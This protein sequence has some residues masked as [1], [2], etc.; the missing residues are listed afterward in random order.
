MISI[1]I[2]TFK[3]PYLLKTLLEKIYSESFKH[4]PHKLEIIIADNDPFHSAKKISEIFI[5]HSTIPLRIIHIPMPNIAA[6][7]NAA[8]G[9]SRGELLAFI[10]DDEIPCNEWLTQMHDAML[11][12][13]ADVIFGPV[14][15]YFHPETPQWIFSGKYFERQRYLTGTSINIS[16][17]RTGNV[18]I[19]R[20]S[21]A[22]IEGPFDLNFGRS[23]GEDT[24]FFKKLQH[25]GCKF[26][27]CDEA[28]V[29]EEVPLERASARWLLKRSYRIGQTWVRTE[30]YPCHGIQ[31]ASYW[32]FLFF[33]SIIQ[34]F[35][36][37]L[38]VIISFCFS[39]KKS[40]QWIRIFVAQIGKLTS[41]AGHQFR[42]YGH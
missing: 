41:L 25:A 21:F 6:A 20:K 30:L 5:N 11:L 14:I 7:R 37:G 12:T 22:S 8:I 9:E 2:C 13:D 3:R 34:L 24:L 40:F 19:R 38:I 33:K 39:P 18:L 28:Q 10:D 23:G 42:E 16:E 29:T 26:S 17:A 32:I 36:S 31:K 15:P 1:C 27:W 4:P 35:I